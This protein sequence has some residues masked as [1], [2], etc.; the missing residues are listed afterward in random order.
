M[1]R[2]STS[3]GFT[4]IELLVVVVVIGVLASIAVPLL[5]RQR[6]AAWQ[7][8]VRADVR[9]AALAVEAGVADGRYPDH[10]D[11]V[12][13]TVVLAADTEVLAGSPA[14]PAAG[15]VSARVSRGVL[16]GYAVSDTGDRFCL[17]GAHE[18]LPATPVAVYDSGGGGLTTQG[19]GFDASFAFG[20]DGAGEPTI[21]ASAFLRP[22]SHPFLY[23]P[24]DEQGGF[25]TRG[26]GL[27]LL[28]DH[29]D[30]GVGAFDLHGA[31]A[32]YAYSGGGW[33]VVVHGQL[34][35]QERF[36]GGYTVQLDRGYAGGEFVL[37]EWVP[38]GQGGATERAPVLRVPAPDFDWDAAHDVRVEVDGPEVRL[39]IDGERVLAYDELRLSQGAFGVRTWGGTNLRTEASQVTVGG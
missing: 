1:R 37:R 15:Q 4:L 28:A 25:L 24:A 26:A 3:E 8:T 20:W 5:L 23:G 11:V 30:L 12:G 16:L 14:A 38:D 19:C 32:T 17:A 22:G 36:V 34:D 27:D 6:E 10:L 13:S 35:E 31:Q 18:Q 9:H 21:L 39:L 2:L 29:H 7:A 33:A